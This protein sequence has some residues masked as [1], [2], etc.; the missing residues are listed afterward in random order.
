[1]FNLSLGFLALQATTGRAAAWHRQECL[2]F[3][4]RV[5]LS[6][7]PLVAVGAVVATASGVAAVT[8]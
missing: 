1:M 6:P 4:V 8:A 5:G 7:Q 2:M 3:N